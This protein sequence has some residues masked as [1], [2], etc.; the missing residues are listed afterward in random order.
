[1]HFGKKSMKR[2]N[3]STYSESLPTKFL[4]QESGASLALSKDGCQAKIF[5]ACDKKTFKYVVYV[6]SL[7]FRLKVK[8]VLDNHIFGMLKA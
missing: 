8:V 4:L 7:T 5:Q 6:M 2:C 1:M 3:G